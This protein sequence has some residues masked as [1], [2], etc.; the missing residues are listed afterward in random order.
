MKPVPQIT[1]ETLADLGLQ[2]VFS[3]AGGMIAPLLDG[4]PESNLQPIFMHHEQ[5]CSMAADAY[6][7]VRGTPAVV[8]V[9]N[10][11]G[12]S[13]A[14]TGVL[15]AFQD[16]VPMV[17]ISGEVS[18]RHQMTAIPQK[19]RQLGVQ[20]APT[21]EMV[22]SITKGV[23]A[24]DK[25]DS[26]QAVLR[27]AFNMAVSGRPGPVWIIM[28]LDIQN[29]QAQEIDTSGHEGRVAPVESSPK[30]IHGARD[31]LA[32]LED[33]S[34]PL[35]LVGHG[36]RLAGAEEKVLRLINQS[37]IPAVAT[38]TGADIFSHD[39]PKYIG[40][41]GILGERAANWAAQ[42]ADLLLVLGS[43]LSIPIIGYETQ[44][45]APRAKVIHVDIDENE[46]NKPTLNSHSRF[47]EDL[48]A[49]VSEIAANLRNDYSCPLPWLE[50]VGDKKKE[51]PLE[52]EEFLETDGCVDAYRVIYELSQL[53]PDDSVIVTDMGTSFTCTMQAFRRQRGI[54]VITSSGTSSMGFGLPGSI[55]AAVSRPEAQVIA[56]VGDGGLQMT[57]QELETLRYRNLPAKIVVLNSGGYLAI[58]LT[59]DSLF[60][61]RRVGSDSLSGLSTPDFCKVGSAYGISSIRISGQQKTF[62]EEFASA[63][64]LSGPALIEIQIP[65]GQKMRPRVQ[66][67]R[68]S[69]GQL[70]SPSLEEM[71]PPHAS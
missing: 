69:K 9:T 65:P 71:W 15:G 67:Y 37:G 54:R 45:F 18:A 68:D 58:S 60:S 31:T 30:E 8:L 27:E 3:V 46:L 23:F 32:L 66:S 34:R 51:H 64:A 12:V 39:D 33:S 4:L 16:S 25:A 20:E 48:S 14:V 44:L 10:G 70:R 29:A 38:W 36:V 24:I 56:V 11:P 47:C 62:Q 21:K 19:V 41:V 13:N 7:R 6:F 57:I 1:W 5:S 17:V 40:N 35:I 50:L 63:L 43:R 42:N 53:A 2:H 61:G 55:G 28:P 26:V 49:F 52:N 22:A 59:Q